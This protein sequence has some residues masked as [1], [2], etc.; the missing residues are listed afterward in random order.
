MD[1][2]VYLF[3]IAIAIE[4]FFLINLLLEKRK[5]HTAEKSEAIKQSSITWSSSYY[6]LH[7]LFGIVGV[8]GVCIVIAYFVAN[9]P[10][11][12]TPAIMRTTS[13]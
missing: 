11:P 5:G 8:F 3:L 13:T 7:I 4:L 12:T 6:K 10:A 1:K 2:W 9:N